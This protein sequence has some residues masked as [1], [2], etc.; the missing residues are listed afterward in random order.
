MVVE[1]WINRDISEICF[2]TTQNPNKLQLVLTGDHFGN[3]YGFYIARANTL[4]PNSP[5]NIL[6]LACVSNSQD[7][8]EVIYEIIKPIIENLT[9]LKKIKL[10]FS[11]FTGFE[12]CPPNKSTLEFQDIP[13][14]KFSTPTEFRAPENLLLYQPGELKA[15]TEEMEICPTCHRKFDTAENCKI[16]EEIDHEIHHER[17]EIKSIHDDFHYYYSQ[18]GVKIPKNKYLSAFDALIFTPKYI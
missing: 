5:A 10:D 1:N 2:H 9:S 4:E 13:V 8:G 15:K 18:K 3:T 12:R 14:H 17:K 7:T 6:P 11:D 16:H